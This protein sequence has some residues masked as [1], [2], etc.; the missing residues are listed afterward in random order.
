MSGKDAETHVLRVQC[1]DEKGLIHK[2]TGVSY[3]H[4]LNIISNDEFV[5]TNKNEFYYR[6]G[7]AGEVDE[8]KFE[9]EI[10]AVLPAGAIV[11]LK[12]LVKKRLVLLATKEM[13]VLGDLLI[14]HLSGDLL[15]DIVAVVANHDT[16]R[17]LVEKFNVPFHFVDHNGVSRERHE[18][19]VL[20]QVGQYQP[21]YLV[22]A[23]YMRILSPKF[24]AAYP[25]RIINIHHSFLPAFIGAN[26]YKQAWNRGV[27]II[28]A[29]SHYVTDNL[30]EGPI[31][32]QDVLPVDHEWSW[33][34][35]ASTGRDVEKIVLA[36]ALKMVLEERVFISGNR[37]VI[38]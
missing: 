25:S 11:E 10:R 36:R 1:A 22:L 30:D 15:A 26:P 27:K 3:R 7:L 4:D 37:T 24:V 9:Q 5:D 8:E 29:T 20:E 19:L 13:H 14:R 28:G 18:E 31:I 2:L 32:Y 12:R 17:P 16:L 38:F 21:D 34:E 35:M 33:Q 6:A 23:K